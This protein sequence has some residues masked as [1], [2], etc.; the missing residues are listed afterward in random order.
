MV[1]KR[2]ITDK[3]KNKIKNIKKFKGK[4]VS[5]MIQAEK[6]ELIELIAKKLNI[7]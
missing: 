4:K 1:V 6:D 5:T 2:L 3:E 7:I